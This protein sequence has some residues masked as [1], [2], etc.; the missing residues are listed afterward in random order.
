[1]S[2]ATKGIG[3]TILPPGCEKLDRHPDLS[4]DQYNAMVKWCRDAIHHNDDFLYDKNLFDKAISIAKQAFN[5]PVE[6]ILS[7]VRNMHLFHVKITS[8]QV[9]AKIDNEYMPRYVDQ[10][11][12]I[13]NIA[14]SARY[15]PYLLARAMLEVI[16]HPIH[17]GRQGVK[18]AVRDPIRKLA[19]P[20]VIAEAYQ[21]SE[22][23][24]GPPM[25]RDSVSYTTD[26]QDIEYNR[27]TRL[28][29]EISHVI[30]LDPMY[31]PGHDERRHI[32]GLK[33]ERLLESLLTSMGT[34]GAAFKLL[35]VLL[36]LWINPLV[37]LCS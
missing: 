8:R 25:C 21:R 32:V 27:A 28:A 30:A 33:Y 5:V 35:E 1:M 7:F 36:V 15:P 10:G 12:S 24:P 22:M 37:L 23:F 16:L 13:W 18:E 4:V 11:E 20:A 31:G 17:V 3:T 9:K 6:S 34:F 2:S 14:K 19:N 26:N 29:R